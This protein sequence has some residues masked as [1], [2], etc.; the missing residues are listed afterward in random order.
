MPMPINRSSRPIDSVCNIPVHLNSLSLL[1]GYT[2]VH[3]D[4]GLSVAACIP[5]MIHVYH[6]QRAGHNIVAAFGKAHRCPLFPLSDRP[7]DDFRFAGDAYD[8]AA[9][10]AMG[11]QPG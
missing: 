8:L 11:A 7:L 9:D 3:P 4:I 1:I 5:L 6:I 2:M 10:F